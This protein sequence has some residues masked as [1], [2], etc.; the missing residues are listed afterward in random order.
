[1]LI[2]EHSNNSGIRQMQ[3]SVAPANF[4][5][6]LFLICFYFFSFKSVLTAYDRNE[7][8]SIE[9]E[10]TGF[11]SLAVDYPLHLVRRGGGGPCVCIID[12]W[13]SNPV[14]IGGQCLSDVKLLM[15]GWNQFT[16]LVRH[17]KMLITE[18]NWCIN[19]NS[20]VLRADHNNLKA[21]LSHKR[22]HTCHN[23]NNLGFQEMYTDA[24]NM[25]CT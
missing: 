8:N 17:I 14:E 21:I 3:Q 1:M 10:S 20:C 7:F 12:A 11:G 16:W 23:H 18:H 25:G 15:W 13:C 5:T 2:C 4:T 22:C 6:F 9:V 19:I 24:C